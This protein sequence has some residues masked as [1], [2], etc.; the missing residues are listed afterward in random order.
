MNILFTEDDFRGNENSPVPEVPVVVVKDSRIA[1]RVVLEVVPLT[2]A[3]AMAARP[4][5]L[6]NNIPDMNRFS[7]PYASET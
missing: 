2:V 5:L 6:P 4:L 7:P 1:N 3:D